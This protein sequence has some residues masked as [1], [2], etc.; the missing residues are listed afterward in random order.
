M[1]DLQNV[2]AQFYYD[3]KKFCSVISLKTNYELIHS[4][5][6]FVMHLEAI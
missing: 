1:R 6:C 4:Q 3:I 5:V 2:L